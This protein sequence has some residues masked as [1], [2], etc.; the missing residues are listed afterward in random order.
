MWQ[1][2]HSP[3]SPAVGRAQIEIVKRALD[4]WNRGDVEAMVA[5][6]SPDGE[7]AIA[8]QNPN[9]RLL[10]GRQEIGDYLRDWLDT[11]HGLH[12]EPE[13]MRDAG[14]AVVVLGKMSGRVGE[15]GPEITAELGFVLHFDGTVVV[16]TEEY[17]DHRQALAAA[18][19]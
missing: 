11:I 1:A 6:A 13:E 8:E 2:A 14:D 4:A 10:R 9:A 18:G 19:L 7:Y 3:Y 17:L 12:Y 15:D 16:R 5:E